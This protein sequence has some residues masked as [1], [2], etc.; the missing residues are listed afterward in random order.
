[1]LNIQLATDAEGH[2]N[3]CINEF[4]VSEI[5]LLIKIKIQ[6]LLLEVVRPTE[7]DDKGL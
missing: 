4:L 2:S 7:V 5:S 1:M 3:I 6:S